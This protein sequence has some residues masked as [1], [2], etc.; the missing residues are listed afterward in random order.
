MPP[1]KRKNP[2]TGKIVRSTPPPNNNNNN[3]PSQSP[4]M[5]KNYAA[6]AAMSQTQNVTNAIMHGQ[7]FSPH[8]H[9]YVYVYF[10]IIN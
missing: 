7:P 1:N 3:G 4:Q 6:M 5:P 9:K 8:M 10:L 2:Q